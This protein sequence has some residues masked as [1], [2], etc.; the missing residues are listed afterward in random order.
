[1]THAPEI[2]TVA[3]L[4]GDPGRMRMLDALMDQRAL[5]A[6]ELA[7]VAGI[8]A[9]AASAHLARLTEAGLLQVVR[10][11]RHRY[12]RIAD[13][14][15]AATIEALGA[16]AACGGPRRH[17]PRTC[18]DARLRRAR[19]CYDHLAGRLGV[20]LFQRLSDGAPP[21]PGD[22]AVRLG[23]QAASM[24]ERLGIAPGAALPGCRPCLDW[25]ERRPHLGGGLGRALAARG[26]ELGWIERRPH[27]RALTVTPAGLA[28]LE[29]HF[30]IQPADLDRDDDGAGPPAKAG[31]GRPDAADA[32]H[33]VAAD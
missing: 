19:L 16:L 7:Y 33:V 15:V 8:G 6:K 24:L 12:F 23:P 27:E 9:P 21:W 4:L 22:D 30:G 14:Q 1:M 5:T 10:Q 26:F 20:L 11:G 13:A 32:R 29:R 3:A 18:R 17:R 31:D 25:S 28:G 2:A